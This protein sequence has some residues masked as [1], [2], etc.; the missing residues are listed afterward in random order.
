MVR[1][2]GGVPVLAHPATRGRGAVVPEDRLAAL[3]DAGL[4]GVEIEHRENTTAGKK[5]LRELAA[6]FGLVVTGSSDYHGA[7]KPN[8]LGENTTAPEVLELI[9]AEGTGSAP[10]GP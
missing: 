8:L 5:R 7:G 6:Q 2:A 9:L 3:V 1:A 4:F 10:F